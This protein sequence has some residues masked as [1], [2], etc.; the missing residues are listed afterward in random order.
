VKN[1]PSGHTKTGKALQ[2]DMIVAYVGKGKELINAFLP[3]HRLDRWRRAAL[4]CEGGR[5]RPRRF[6]ID[7]AERSGV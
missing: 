4:A 7:M 2:C 3:G 5:G 6:F 1:L